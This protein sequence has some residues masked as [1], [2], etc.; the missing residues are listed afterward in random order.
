MTLDAPTDDGPTAAE[1]ALARLLG[2]MRRLRDPEAGCPWDKAQTFA[3][4]AP[5][6]IEEAY[7]VA[8]AIEEQ[9]FDG[10]RDE[11]GDLLFQVVFHSRMA[12]EL[13][14]FGFAEVADAISDKMVRRHPHIFGN[15]AD[16]SGDATHWEA[17]KEA[18]RAARAGDRLQS[19]LDGVPAALPALVRADKLQRRAARV[20][21]DWPDADA[22]LPK[23]DE[24]LAEI[25]EARAAAPDR[26]AEEVGDLLFSV[27]NLARKLNID[28][29]VA[30]RKANSKFDRRFRGIE[31]A[32]LAEGRR[33]QDATLA[34][35][36]A[37]WVAGKLSSAVRNGS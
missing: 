19:V 20:G 13:G 36:E 6:T 34:E 5:Y 28:A 16:G 33:P 24:E 11:L 12:E 10:L 1:R 30:L 15:A 31:A 2:I 37:L 4:I 23:I 22:V 14:R 21:F 3:T 8:D 26:V 32:L 9:D 29:E 7:E 25:A 35:M 18:E 17:L 27:V